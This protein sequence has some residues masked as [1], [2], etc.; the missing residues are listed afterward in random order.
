M[1]SKNEIRYQLQKIA[2]ASG[3]AICEMLLQIV[4]SLPKETKIGF[5]AVQSI[6]LIIIIWSRSNC[7]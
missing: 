1:R 6:I 5:A 2:A 4:N 3:Y 7:N